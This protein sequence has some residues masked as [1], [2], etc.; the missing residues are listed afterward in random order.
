M[1]TEITVI[2]LAR[3]AERRASFARQAEAAG[4][5]WRF[6]DACTALTP[7]L[8]YDPADS[9]IAWGRALTPG[10]LGVYASHYSLWQGLIASGADQLI[11]FEDDTLVDW[12]FIRRISEIDFSAQGVQFLKLFSRIASPCKCLRWEYI[13]PS[14]SLIRFTDYALGAQAYLITRS[15]AQTLV[16]HCRRV[17]RPIDHEME[18]FWAHGL[19][20]LAVYPFPVIEISSPSRI[21]E[22]MFCEP[23]SAASWELRGRRLASRALEKARRAAARFAPEPQLSL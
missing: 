6:F 13:E 4:V 10:E 3:D 14:R 5:D 16:R 20:N 17:R 1:K 18:R 22:R 12:A 8:Q 21:G 7:A 15:G 19:P 23:L 11:A 2:S 9:I